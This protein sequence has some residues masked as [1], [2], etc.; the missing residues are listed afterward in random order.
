M[1]CRFY[2]SS[3]ILSILLVKTPSYTQRDQ[4]YAAEETNYAQ[5]TKTKRGKSQKTFKRGDS[6]VPS[7]TQEKDYWS[8]KIDINYSS[9]ISR[10]IFSD[11]YMVQ[12]G[13]V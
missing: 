5:R 13:K 7:G 2:T 10:L 6:T 12:N 3:L 1:H 9:S 11:F 8:R 4:V